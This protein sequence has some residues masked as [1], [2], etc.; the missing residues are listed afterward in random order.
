ML[1]AYPDNRLGRFLLW[2]LAALVL[3]FLVLPTLVVIPLSFSGSNFLEFPPRSLSLRWYENFFGSGAWMA[4][5]R[6]SIL[7]GV[8]TPMLAVPLGFLCCVGMNRLS[9][10]ASRAIYGYVLM[11][12]ILP[13]ILLAIGLFFVLAKMKLIG[14]V[15]G[16]LI[17]HAVLAIP[18]VVIVLAPAVNRFDWAQVMAARSLGAGWF[19]GLAGIMVP[20]LRFSFLA[21][22]LMAFLTSLDE[23][24]ISIFVSGGANSTLP[25][26]MFLSLRDQIDPTIAA[27]STLW[28]GFIIAIVLI[29]NTCQKS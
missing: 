4:A 1:D 5:L 17:G 8:L 6:T 12:S 10:K 9:G 7:L 22:A 15:V 20:Q 14:T 13:G 2:L 21:A 26:L 11:P 18:V 19:R 25:K 3:T 24:V 27:I 16:V 23:A 28:T 29:V